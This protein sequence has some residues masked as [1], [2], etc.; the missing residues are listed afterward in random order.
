MFHVEHYESMGVTVS[1]I[2]PIR[3]GHLKEA[4]WG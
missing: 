2:I 1:S 4:G 3:R